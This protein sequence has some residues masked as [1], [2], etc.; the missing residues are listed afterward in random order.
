MKSMHKMFTPTRKIKHSAAESCYTPAIEITHR[1]GA[2][3]RALRADRDRR[4]PDARLQQAPE[5][6]RRRP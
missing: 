6:S 4:S 2:R 3:N 1:T 5:W